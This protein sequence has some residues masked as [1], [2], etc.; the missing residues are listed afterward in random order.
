MG[1]R[2]AIGQFNEITTETM[3]F[4]RQLGIDSVQMNTPLL[5]GADTWDAADVQRLADAVAA[6]GLKLEAIE[7]VPVHFYDKVMTGAPGREAQI[8]NYCAIIRALG[9]AGIGILGYHFMPNSVWRTNRRIKGRGGARNT[10]FDLAEA[11]AATT[12]AEAERFLP[13]VLGDLSAMPLRFGDD[14]GIS[15]DQMWDNYA[16]FLDRVLPVAEE[17]GV[18]LALHPDDPPASELGGVARL[19]TGVENFKR[20]E[21]LAKDSPAWALDLCLGSCSS[22]VGGAQTV[23]E[24]ISHFGPRGKIAYV[25][26]R[27]VQGSVPSFVE[28]FLGEGN[29]NP[30]EMIGLLRDNG[31]DGFLLD[32]HVPQI[33]NDSPWGHRARGHAIGYLQGLLNAHPQREV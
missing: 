2:V 7:N 1:M 25:H 15:H 31:F 22:M 20:A 5:P 21:A 28:C 4:A 8:E 19:F 14:A 11:T 27:D 29:F 24:M 33:E 3:A 10:G 6:E 17:A 32:D 12:R 9:A 26:F 13:S 30:S 18:R 16:W 23:R